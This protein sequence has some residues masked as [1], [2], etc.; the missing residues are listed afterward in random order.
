MLSVCACACV[1]VWACVSEQPNSKQKSKANADHNC[2][3][4][5]FRTDVGS[6]IVHC[7]C[8][9][10]RILHAWLTLRM[11]ATTIS[12]T[13]NAHGLSVHTSQTS[14]NKE[15]TQ[16]AFSWRVHIDF[17][18]LLR[19]KNFFWCS[20]RN[21]NALIN[22]R[23]AEKSWKFYVKKT[24]QFKSEKIYWNFSVLDLWTLW[25]VEIWTNL[26]RFLCCA[27]AWYTN[28]W[29]VC[30]RVCV[31]KFKRWI[32]CEFWFC[33]AWPMAWNQ[34]KMS[35]RYWRQSTYRPVSCIWLLY[36]TIW[37]RAQNTNTHHYCRSI[38]ITHYFV[39]VVLCFEFFFIVVLLSFSLSMRRWVM[40][41]ALEQKFQRS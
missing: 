32:I 21:I 31:S 8:P 40:R 9:L 28:D 5:N 23:V 3:T 13:A 7:L 15:N 36:P 20:N 29:C 22:E 4:T 6:L 37:K 41:N 38:L 25:W 26:L 16:S 11:W 1:R 2:Q 35:R 34:L 19:K 27:D 17:S 30:V 14:T 18:L 39:N 33:N 24:I 10:L 12:S